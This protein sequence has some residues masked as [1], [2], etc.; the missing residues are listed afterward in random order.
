MLPSLN[1]MEVE[2]CV[3]NLPVFFIFFSGANKTAPFQE[4]GMA[5]FCCLA[6]LQSFSLIIAGICTG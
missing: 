4:N 6:K 1:C 5:L 2:S 3:D